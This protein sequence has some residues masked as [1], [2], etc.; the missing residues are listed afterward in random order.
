MSVENAEVALRMVLHRE[1]MDERKLAATLVLGGQVRFDGWGKN[2][3]FRVLGYS[4]SFEKA[5]EVGLKEITDN[6][7][8][9]SLK[10]EQ[11]Y[12]QLSLE[13]WTPSGPRALRVGR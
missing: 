10:N 8:D 13:L 5:I 9:L 1:W 3:Q 2:P 11:F 4:K 6:T 12:G 7:P